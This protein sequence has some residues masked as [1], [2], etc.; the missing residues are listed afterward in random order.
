MANAGELTRIARFL[1]VGLLTTCIGLSVIYAC[2][3]LG[4]IS[5]SGRGAPGHLWVLRSVLRTEPPQDPL[6]AKLAR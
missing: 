2:K 3:Y 5:D 4:Q 6:S 1:A